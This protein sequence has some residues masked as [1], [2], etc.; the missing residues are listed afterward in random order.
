MKLTICK[1]QDTEHLQ[2][3]ADQDEILHITG[4]SGCGK[5]VIF[6]AIYWCLYGVVKDVEKRGAEGRKMYVRYEPRNGVCIYRQR[7]PKAFTVTCEERTYEGLLAQQKVLELIGADKDGWLATS[8]VHQG[9]KPHF[10]LTLP[11]KER[12]HVLLRLSMGGEDAEPYVKKIQEKI[13]SLEDQYKERKKMHEQKLLEYEQLCQRYNV[14]FDNIL[15]SDEQRYHEEYIVKVTENI[16][17]L[18]KELSAAKERESKVSL[19]SNSLLRLEK[20]RTPLLDYTEVGLKNLEENNRFC[21]EFEKLSQELAICEKQLINLEKKKASC[22]V[23]GISYVQPITLELIG[24]V[25]VAEKEWLVNHKIAEELEIDYEEHAI[26][27]EIEH[28]RVVLDSQEKAALYALTRK[29]LQERDDLLSSL[30]A[31]PSFSFD[32]LEEQ[33]PSLK[34]KLETLNNS[35]VLSTK[36][37]STQ[38]SQQLTTQLKA[39]QEDFLN[40]RTNNKTQYEQRLLE[41]KKSWTEKKTELIHKEKDAEQKVEQLSRARAIHQCPH[42][43]KGLR[44]VNEKLE[45]SSEEPFDIARY[46]STK[47][48]LSEAKNKLSVLE[49]EE[50][51]SKQTLHKEF[52]QTQARL[53]KQSKDK[54]N[55][56]RKSILTEEKTRLGL[57]QQAHEQE[58]N[59]LKGKLNTFLDQMQVWSALKEKRKQLQ[60]CNLEIEALPDLS[61]TLS[62]TEILSALQI[63]QLKKRLEKL[64]TIRVVEKPIIS[65]LNLRNLLETKKCTE[66]IEQQT[67]LQAKLKTSLSSLPPLQKTSSAQNYR[68]KLQ[69]KLLVESQIAAY[70]QDLANIDQARPSR[71]IEKELQTS[72][73]KKTNSEKALL[74]SKRATTLMRDYNAL[75]ESSDQCQLLE[76]KQMS[77]QQLLKVVQDTMVESLAGVINTTNA[78]LAAVVPKLFN[79]PIEIR[80]ATQKELKSGN[81]KQ[82]ISLV[83]NYKGGIV[84]N[85]EKGLSAG[86]KVRINTILSLAF[87]QHCNSPV[88]IMD[89]AVSLLNDLTAHGLMDLVRDDNYGATN[90]VVLLASQNCSSGLVDRAVA[91]ENLIK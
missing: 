73:T 19:V 36:L 88:F 68:Q 76:E 79:D 63:G 50:A 44:Y 22:S 81:K 24:Q 20:Q 55:E 59:V 89:E 21:L 82:E 67:I 69:E 26:A 30:P 90:R 43:N 84:H 27:E 18:N 17:I 6:E 35:L 54:E 85:F 52:E 80:L 65:A 49:K 5:S 45:K 9:S 40:Q 71:E 8:Y 75:T 78:Y 46:V 86:E 32:F 60:T 48:Q 74:R 64:S 57:L 87:A 56:L 12:Y 37:L 7:N 14:T 28:C 3:T 10:I 2:L 51:E 33:I 31:E 72:K 83:V 41:L 47:Q 91:Y 13:K 38:F 42:C 1:F 29:K 15:T 62:C 58:S 53:D 11:P 23:N 61:T 4:D 70:K 16:S 66:E 34:Q 39:Q 25:E 77:F